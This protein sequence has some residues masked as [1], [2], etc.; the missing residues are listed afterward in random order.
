MYFLSKILLYNFLIIHWQLQLMKR[1]GRLAFIISH[2]D[3][4]KNGAVSYF[5]RGVMFYPFLWILCPETILAY[6]RLIPVNFKFEGWEGYL[7]TLWSTMHTPKIPKE[8]PRWIKLFHDGNSYFIKT[9]PLICRG[10]L[11]LFLVLSRKSFV[12]W[13]VYGTRW[14]SNKIR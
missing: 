1:W 6:F 10:N 11:V 14:H 9:S 2:T 5:C 7:P 13:Q 3:W 8:M 12:K 4:N